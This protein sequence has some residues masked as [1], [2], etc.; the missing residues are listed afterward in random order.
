MRKF[1]FLLLI[2][3][4]YSTSKLTYA[5]NSWQ[6][7]L[8]GVGSVSYSIENSEAVN[9]SGQSCYNCLTVTNA[10]PLSNVFSINYAGSGN[11]GTTSGGAVWTF[12]DQQLSIANQVAPEFGDTPLYW[13]TVGTL[14]FNY[15][16]TIYQCNNVP[17]VLLVP[18]AM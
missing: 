8:N 18:I 1:I 9:S 6:V 3:V 12:I 11:A 17:I 13:V 2:F 10:T 5:Q 16:G 4:F 15:N 7:M 14:S